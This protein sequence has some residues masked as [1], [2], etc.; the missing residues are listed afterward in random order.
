MISWL[1]GESVFLRKQRRL[2]EEQKPT[3]PLRRQRRQLEEQR[4]TGLQR[5]VILCFLTTQE[6]WS[7]TRVL[8]V[9]QLGEDPCLA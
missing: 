2:L 8:V 7:W 4:P 3:N 6:S 9:L 5:V 1:G